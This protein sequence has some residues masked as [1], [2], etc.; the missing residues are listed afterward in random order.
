MMKV[1]REWNDVPEVFGPVAA[2]LEQEVNEWSDD[3]IDVISTEEQSGYA[4]DGMIY[5]RINGKKYCLEL[6]EIL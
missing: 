3:N 1:K 2:A 4:D 6:H 5:I